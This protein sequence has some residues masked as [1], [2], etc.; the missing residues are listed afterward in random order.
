MALLIL[1]VPLNIECL[2]GSLKQSKPPR[3]V[4]QA[5]FIFESLQQGLELLLALV[6]AATR[7]RDVPGAVFQC[8]QES[9][10]GTFL[11]LETLLDLVRGGATGGVAEALGYRARKHATVA[12]AVVV[13]VVVGAVA[14][15]VVS[16][17]SGSRRVDAVV[18]LC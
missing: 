11:K 10:G 15:A 16:S 17:R 7:G 4:V 14:V 18:S 9:L 5:S 12:V 3:R 2:Q 8:P 6:E 13:V 1:E